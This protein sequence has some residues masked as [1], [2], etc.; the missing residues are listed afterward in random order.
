MLG[1]PWQFGDNSIT[2]QDATFAS[3]FTGQDGTEYQAPDGYQYIIVTA[4]LTLVSVRWS[5]LNDFPLD[6]GSADAVYPIDQDLSQALT[7]VNFYTA[8]T[9]APA[10]I[11]LVYQVPTAIDDLTRC[12]IYVS[13]GSDSHGYAV[14]KDF[15]LMAN[16]QG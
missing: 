9:T 13:L 6:N 11:K 10:R 4:D 15:V 3:N 2:M 8:T 7:G 5:D 16:P 14:D 12:S 1:T